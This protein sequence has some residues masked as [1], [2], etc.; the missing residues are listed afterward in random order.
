MISGLHPVGPSPWLSELAA[1]PEPS[2]EMHCQ[3]SK[4]T[5]GAQDVRGTKV[6][7]VCILQ[8]KGRET[9]SMFQG[10]RGGLRPG[11]QSQLPDV[12]SALGV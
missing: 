6:H 12:D 9:T 5:P 10:S 7:R 4:A 3:D 1:R 11:P 8:T 2:P